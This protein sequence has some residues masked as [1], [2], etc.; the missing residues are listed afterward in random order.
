MIVVAQR[1]CITNSTIRKVL[2]V[3]NEVR[4]EVKNEVENEVKNEVKNEVI[5]QKPGNY[6]ND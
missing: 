5:A 6:L 1:G 4:N 3:R 2:E